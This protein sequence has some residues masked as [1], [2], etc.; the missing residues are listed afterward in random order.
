M[1]S[2]TI[3]AVAILTSAFL[4]VALIPVVG[5]V[6]VIFT[7]LPV[8]YY[9]SQLGRLK[10]LA[11]LAAS[12]LAAFGILS[13]AGQRVSLAVLFTIGFTGV[14]LAEILKRRF[15]LEKTFL[16]GSS[17]LF[18]LGAGVVLFHSLRAGIAPWQTVEL[19]VSEIVRHNIAFYS[20]L[21]IPEEQIQLI[22][23]SVPQ[24]TRIFTGIFPALAFSGAVLTVWVNLLAGRA[25]FRIKETPFPDFGDLS[26]WK[27]PERLVWLLIAAGV[28][29]L[30]PAERVSAT[31]MNLLIVCSL[32]YLFQ[33]LAIVSFFFQKKRV[34]MILRWLFY[35]LLLIQQY[36]LVIVIALGLFDL[37]VDFRK[38]IGGTG[39]V[40]AA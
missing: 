34:P 35:G 32:V 6:V 29:T 23:D 3:L 37:W 16:W 39:N 25:L 5:P 40:P 11:V 15:S 10:G 26:A 13:T 21:N 27:A 1:H 12:Y 9:Y 2:G 28:M 30:L 31:G 14:L 19:Y 24:I 38:R 36:M 18:C 8:L 33:G 17:A 7:P 20:Q 22:R 4:F